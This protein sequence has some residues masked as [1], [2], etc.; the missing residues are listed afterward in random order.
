KQIEAIHRH[1][2]GAVSLLETT[3]PQ[4]RIAVEGADIV[5]T[6]EAALENVVASRILA[7]DPP[8]EVD[9]QLVE[10]ALEELAILASVIFRLDL[11]HAKRSP[12]MDRWIDV[13]EIPLVGGNLAVRVHVPFAGEQK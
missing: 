8:G 13:A 7:I 6:E 5:E 3:A 2:A 4:F 10:N 12:C 9:H 11:I 1:P